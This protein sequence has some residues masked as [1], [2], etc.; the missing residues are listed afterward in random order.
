MKANVHP[1]MY[2][3]EKVVTALYSSNVKLAIPITNHNP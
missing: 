2:N 1:P 3:T